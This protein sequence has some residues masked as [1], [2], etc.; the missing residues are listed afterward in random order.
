[1]PK[2]YVMQG[3][4]ASGKSTKAEEIYRKDP[5]HTVYASRDRIRMCLGDYWQPD[6]EYLVTLIQVNMIEEALELGFNVI[7]DD[8]NLNP[9]FIKKWR[10]IAP[11]YDA[12][13]EVISIYTPF[14]ECLRRN[15]NPDR[16]HIPDKVIRQFFGQYKINKETGEYDTEE[17]T[18]D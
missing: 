3:P 5:E 6:R 9:K 13:L 15:S 7:I 8:T 14:K 1:M 2:I 4:P 16:N 12:D 10:M 17:R 11:L 18:E